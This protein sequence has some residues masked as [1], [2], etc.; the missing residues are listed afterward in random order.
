MSTLPPKADVGTG[1]CIRIASITFVGFVFG[2]PMRLT[3]TTAE[4][5]R[6]SGRTAIVGEP[7]VRLG[8]TYARAWS[9]PTLHLLQSR[10]PQISKV[11]DRAANKSKTNPKPPQRQPR[12]FRCQP[13][14][15]GLS[16]KFRFGVEK[17]PCSR[18]GIGAMASRI[19]DMGNQ[20]GGNHD[21]CRISGCD[22]SD[23]LDCMGRVGAAHAGKLSGAN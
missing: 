12:A 10:N 18:R 4:L 2:A 17:L 20:N 6:S 13:V 7:A 23:R 9:P 5:G 8:E 19:S 11:H 15:R 3:E 14:Q 22:C 21:D 16:K 1:T